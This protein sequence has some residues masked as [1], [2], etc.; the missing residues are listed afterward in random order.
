M[1]TL[2]ELRHMEGGR[3]PNYSEA[4]QMAKAAYGSVPEMVGPFRLKKY[5]PAQS[6]AFYEDD[7]GTMVAA[8]AGT[9]SAHEALT[10]WWRVPTNQVEG[11]ERYRQAEAAIRQA[12]REFPDVLEW[13]GVG[14]SLGGAI[15]DSLIE[16]GLLDGGHTFNPAIQTQHLSARQEHLRLPGLFG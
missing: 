2:R 3:Y 4:Q 13:Y 8:I 5:N 14:H 12:R 1:L 10:E 11:G 7:E 6:V 9:Q 16:K 15:I